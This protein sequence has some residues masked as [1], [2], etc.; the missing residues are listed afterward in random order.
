MGDGDLGGS[1]QK[2]PES[3]KAR[4]SQYPMGMTSA[5]IPHKGKGEPVK[6]I[7]TG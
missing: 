7:S 2:V 3:R 5:E 1:N 4:A 6:T